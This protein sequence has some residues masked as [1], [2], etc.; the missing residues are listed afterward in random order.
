MTRDGD[1]KKQRYIYR[2]DFSEGYGEKSHDVKMG[3][4]MGNLRILCCT[5]ID[6]YLE[7]ST[8]YHQSIWI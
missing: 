6:R 8:I 2:T 7:R 4:L 5:Y 1:R 3:K